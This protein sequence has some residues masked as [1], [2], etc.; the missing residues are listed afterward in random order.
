MIGSVR[1]SLD[2][3]SAIRRVTESRA[4]T[5]LLVEQRVDIALDIASR[6]LIMDRGRIVHEGASAA[7]RQDRT[8]LESLLGF[9]H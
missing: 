5:V 6:C 3:T 1:C 4:L 7:L 2:F 9:E 8:Q